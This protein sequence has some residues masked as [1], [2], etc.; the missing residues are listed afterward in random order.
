MERSTSL[1]GLELGRSAAV[2][3]VRGEPAMAVRLMEMGFVP[4]TH[5]K[6]IK[7]APMGDPLQFQLR[8]Y[9]ISLRRAEAAMVMVKRI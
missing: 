8:G 4:G 3:A 6:L 9:H 7:R 5:V 1:D 2:E